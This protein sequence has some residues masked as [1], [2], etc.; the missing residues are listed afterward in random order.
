MW[1]FSFPAIYYAE[2]RTAA[3]IKKATYKRRRAK[4]VYP[5]TA[6]D[7]VGRSFVGW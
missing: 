2:E 1:Y 6:N 5:I 4:A 7:P 3:L